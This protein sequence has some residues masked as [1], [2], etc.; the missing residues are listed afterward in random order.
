MGGRRVVIT[1]IGVV[2]AIGHDRQRFWESLT[3]GKHGFDTIELSETTGFQ[4]DRGAEIKGLDL[5]KPFHVSSRGLLDRFARLWLLAAREAVADSGLEDGALTEAAVVTGTA[6]GGQTTQDTLFKAVYV[7]GRRRLTPFTVP[8]I[9]SNA[10]ASQASMEVGIEGP[11]LTISTACSSSTHSLGMAFWMVKMGTVDRALTGGSEAPFSY[12]H[13]KGWDSMRVMAPDVCRPFSRD[14]RGMILGEGGAAFVLEELESALERGATIHAEVLGF[15]MSS[16]AGHITKP[17]ASGAGRAI[18]AALKDAGLD[19]DA[20]DYINA[21]GTGTT[22][23]D[24]TEAM[25]IHE[26]FGERGSRIPVSSTKSMHGHGLGAAGALEAA[27]TALALEHGVLPPTANFSEPDP[28]CELDVIPNESREVRIR[29]A[30][31][32]SFAFGGLNAVVV[33][34]EPPGRS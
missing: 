18:R 6:L 21:H 34:G 17:S 28:E 23:N 20:I 16:D 7:E 22:L 31:S 13:L 24:S 30:I 9:M 2:S 10:G 3:A 11:G 26:T 25:A 8:K 33:L 32:N 19:S 4:F 14:R 27:A 15:G 5:D 1:G 12:G 29:R